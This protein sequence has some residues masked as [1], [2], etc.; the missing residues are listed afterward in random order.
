M[1]PLLDLRIYF[2]SKSSHGGYGSTLKPRQLDFSYKSKKQSASPFLLQSLSRRTAQSLGNSRTELMQL[3][4]T[5]LKGP[6]SIQEGPN[7][8][9]CIVGF[10][11]VSEAFPGGL[12][13]LA[14]LQH[15]DSIS[16]GFTHPLSSEDGRASLRARVWHSDR[17]EAAPAARIQSL[18]I[19][20]LPFFCR[21]L[22]LIFLNDL[23]NIFPCSLLVSN[24]VSICRYKPHKQ[25][26]WSS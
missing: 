11:E 23:I 18:R 3:G 15:M 21:G 16:D 17:S 13:G 9:K 6:D 26:L 5:T 10:P 8:S 19:R 14:T 20:K 1:L 24:R 25:P 7:D 22:L 2:H 4:H 12:R